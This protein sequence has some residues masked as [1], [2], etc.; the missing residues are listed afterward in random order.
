MGAHEPAASA[1]VHVVPQA[2]TALRESSE[3][4]VP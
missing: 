3:V 2:D 1:S 4:H